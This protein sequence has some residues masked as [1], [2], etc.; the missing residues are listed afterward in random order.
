MKQAKVAIRIFFY[1]LLVGVFTI[2]TAYNS[3]AQSQ[4]LNGQIEGTI[5]DSSG[6]AVPNATVVIKNT[7]PEPLELLL[8]TAA[9]F[10]E[11]HYFRS[12]R[13]RLRSKPR[14]LNALFAMAS[15]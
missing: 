14:T 1:C 4:A 2:G 13:T 11:H 12:G 10:I 8:P 5:T 9:A 6:G 3:Q 15:L 7:Q